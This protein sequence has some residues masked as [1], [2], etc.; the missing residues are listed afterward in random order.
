VDTTTEGHLWAERYDRDLKEIFALQDEVA[1]KIVAAL[2]VKLTEGEQE[3]LVRKSTDNM[4]AYDY[5]L[6][7]AEY[8]HRFTKEANAEARQMSEKAIELDPEY[9]SAHLL[10]GW[11][12]LL[13]WILGWSHDPQS[14]ERAFELAQTALSLDNS[15]PEA[16][17]LLGNIYLSKNQH[18]QAI[19]VCEKAIALN[20]NYAD[21]FA[22]LGEILNWAG[23]SEEALELLKRAMRLN[24]GYPLWYIWNL[25]HAYFLTGRFEMAISAL[26]T[27]LERNPNWPIL[28]RGY[29]VAS[30]DELGLE[31]EAR[32][33]AAEVLRINPKFS[34]EDFSKTLRYKNQAD[35]EHLINAVRKAGLK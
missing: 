24:P 7:G 31:K 30:Y 14:L 19:V 3:R 28:V 21:G 27:L 10:L 16:Y 11:T 17:R 32:A 33:A 9:A 6:R 23:R 2:E 29:L 8:I 22:A 15:L 34:L 1:Q 20:P 12:H 35:T 4:E 18:E 13:D 5:Y 25:G 26:R